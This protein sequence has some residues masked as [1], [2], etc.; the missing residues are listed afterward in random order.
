MADGAVTL[1]HCEIKRSRM[2]QNMELFVNSSTKI[3]QADREITVLSTL[4]NVPQDTTI[5]NIYKTVDFQQVSC[6]AKVLSVDEPMQVSGGKRKQDITIS[7]SSG[8]I[9]LTVWEE[10]INK[11]DE[12]TSYHL[13]GVTVS[14]F[15][16]KKFLSSSKDLF[17]F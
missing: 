12:D 11:L 10:Y 16:G 4:V 7:D 14:T 5:G 8:S 9:R 17:K 15:K 2:G 13:S 3:K 1:S 6:T